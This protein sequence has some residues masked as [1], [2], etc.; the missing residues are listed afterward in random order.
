MV[1]IFFALPVFSK[2][3]EN[4]SQVIK[5]GIS[6]DWI[7]KSQMQRDE[8]VKQIQNTLF[9]DK[10]VLKYPKKEF[11]EKYA[12]VWK[13]KEYLKNYDGI[14]NGLKEDADK[15]YCGFYWDKVLVAYGIQYKNNMSNIYYYD[16]MGNF[17]W[18]D[19]FSSGYPKF[20]YWSY[21]YSRSGKL[22]AAYYYISEY[23]QYAFDANKKFKGRWYKDNLYNQNARIIMSRTNY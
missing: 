8:S 14:S 23:D 18:V 17:R 3:A 7:S 20:P 11:K 19:V 4:D 21:Q 10:F 6:F 9:N 16:A 13:D 5:I 12:D 15:K 22:A 1:L 2:N